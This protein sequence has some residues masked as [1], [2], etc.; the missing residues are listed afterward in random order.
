V[1]QESL[2]DAI[3]L[4]PQDPM[5]FHRSLRENIAYGRPNATME[6]I[7]NASKM[8]RCHEFIQ[9]LSEGYETFVGERGIKLS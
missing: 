3:S 7:I 4:V 2:R 6:E 9:S 5:L 8:A 1:T